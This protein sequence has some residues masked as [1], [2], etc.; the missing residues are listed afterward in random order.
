MG[1]DLAKSIAVL[2]VEWKRYAGY[3]EHVSNNRDR[4]PGGKG[5]SRSHDRAA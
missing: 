2:M 1:H 5:G 3:G 4:G